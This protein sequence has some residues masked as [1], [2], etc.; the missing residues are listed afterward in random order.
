MSTKYIFAD[1][2]GCFNFYRNQNASKYFILCSITMDS[3]DLDSEIL[4]LRRELLWRDMEKIGDYFHASN[5]KQAVRDEMFSLIRKF[6]FTIQATILEKAKAQPHIRRARHDLYKYGWYYHF[7]HGLKIQT[8]GACKVHVCAAS[9][10]NKKEKLS[11]SNA[12]SSVMEQ[13]NIKNWRTD[14]RQSN[15]DPCLQAVDYCAWAIQRKWEM[16]DTR[17]YDLIKE[18][19]TR[20]YD[21]WKKGSVLYY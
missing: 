10:G 4:N 14:I 13:M 20:E 8:H 2:A 15:T 6:P 11:F 3:C 9:I 18:K 12:I 7:K 17:S 5:D 19:I 16:S 1:E 21:L